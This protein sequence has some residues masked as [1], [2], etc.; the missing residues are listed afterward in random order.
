MYMICVSQLL[1]LFIFFF[2]VISRYSN[3]PYSLG[4]IVF[5]FYRLIEIKLDFRF[6]FYS[7][8]VYFFPILYI[9]M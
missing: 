2:T 5:F 4:S 9:C 1:N 3:D 6:I 8:I 7:F